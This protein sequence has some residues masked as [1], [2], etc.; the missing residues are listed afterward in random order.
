[1]TRRWWYLP[2]TTAIS[3]IT[4]VIIS[5]MKDAAS[6]PCIFL[7]GKKGNSISVEACQQYIL[8][9]KLQEKKNQDHHWQHD[10]NSCYFQQRQAGVHNTVDAQMVTGEMRHCQYFFIMVDYVTNSPFLQLSEMATHREN[11]SRHMRNG[12]LVVVLTRAIQSRARPAPLVLNGIDI[13]I[14]R[15][16]CLPTVSLGHTGLLH[17]SLSKRS[18]ECTVPEF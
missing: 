8:W 17:H 16:K 9:Q 10:F 14:S 11:Q 18:L 2:L 1:M 4:S 5:E 7:V 6:A 3:C 12:G 13:Q 15:R